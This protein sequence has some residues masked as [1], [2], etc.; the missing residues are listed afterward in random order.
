MS[1]SSS[2][3]LL[4]SDVVIDDVA[5]TAVVTIEAVIG[6]TESTV[7]VVSPVSS[8]NCSGT[9]AIDG[10]DGGDGDG[11]GCDV[12]TIGGAV[13]VFVTVATSSMSESMP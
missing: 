1:S 3:E 6:V 11:N 5:G 12:M 10:N 7:L 9:T 8:A 2:V 13:G 4:L